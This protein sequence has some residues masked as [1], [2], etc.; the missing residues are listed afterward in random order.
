[1]SLLQIYWSFPLVKKQISGFAKNLR[2]HLQYWLVG[3]LMQREKDKE[4]E[5]GAKICISLPLAGGHIG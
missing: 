2:S 5:V 3:W 1:M 4:D